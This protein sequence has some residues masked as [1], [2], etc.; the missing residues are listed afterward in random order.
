MASSL[1]RIL[2]TGGQGQLASALSLYFPY[3]TYASKQD[4][5]VTD[6]DGCRRLFSGQS[7]DLVIHTAAE[8]SYSAPKDVLRTVNVLGTANVTYWAERHNARLVY[9]STDY[10]YPGTHGGYRETD[11]V[12]PIGD[13]ARSKYSGECAAL[14]YENSLAIRTSFYT[15]LHWYSAA[16][17]AF[18]SRM[19]IHQAA[20]LIAGLATSSA[21]GV[22][23]VGGP[24]RSL[25]E[26]VVEEFNPK[27]RPINRSEVNLPY[28]LPRD[29]SLNCDRMRAILG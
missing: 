12:A 7:F 2:I 28:I 26:I 15:E 23:N 8:I 16:T 25:Y 24:R 17:D 18:S 14:Q 11:P 22:V 27:A 3:A 6:M 1:T 4:L 29:V 13:Y 5:D 9:I 10:C 20:P 19:P 21:T